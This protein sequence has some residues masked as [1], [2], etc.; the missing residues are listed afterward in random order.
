MRRD[1]VAYDGG[2]FQARRDTG[3]PPSHAAHWLCL[4]TAGRDG[5]SITV[6]GTFDES[7]DYR[8]LDVVACNGGSFIALKDPPGPCPGSG[9]QLLATPGRRGAA[10]EKG[11]RG[12]RGPQS[13]P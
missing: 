8:R 10:G 2:M 9:W 13:D 4:A 3:Q 11:G 1:V 5:N 6:R 12:E 7:A